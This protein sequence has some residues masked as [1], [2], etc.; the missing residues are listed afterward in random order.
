MSLQDDIKKLNKLSKKANARIRE[1]EKRGQTQGRAYLGLDY[2]VN[3]KRAVRFSEHNKIYNTLDLAV[4]I[5]NVMNFLEDP[6]ST[7]KGYKQEY[8]YTDT[9]DRIF[10][11]LESRGITF[12]NEEG[13][14]KEEQFYN[15]LHS[16]QYKALSQMADSDE[17]IEIYLRSVDRADKSTIRR[18]FEKFKKGLVTLDEVSVRLT[19]KNVFIDDYD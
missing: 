7:D 16:Q 11:A 4:A 9:R 12:A 6:T 3:K 1:L 8:V 18:E 10:D 13:L 2:D 19:G 5:D 15:F 14:G 17:V